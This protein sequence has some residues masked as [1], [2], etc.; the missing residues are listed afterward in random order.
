MHR[1]RDLWYL[2]LA[3]AGIVLVAMLSGCG[4]ET[5]ASDITLQ[6]P[7][8]S[9]PLVDVVLLLDQSGSM[10]GANG[11]DPNGVRVEA[12]K[13]L[14]AN[15]SEKSAEDAPNRIAIVDF[16]D[17]VKPTSASLQ[18]VSPTA[19]YAEVSAKVGVKSMGG[20][21]ALGALKAALG[22]LQ[23]AG[24]FDQGRK[25]RIVLFTDGKPEDDR[26]LTLDQYFKELK[27]FV[28]A[29]LTPLGCEVYVIAVDQVGDIWSACGSRWQ[30]LVGQDHVVRIRSVGELR[31][32]F[33]EVVN[34]I[35][36]IPSVPPDILTAGRK[37]F[38]VRPYL[39]RVEFH[40]FPSTP[41]MKLRITRPNGMP[42]S[43]TTDTD[44]RQREFKGYQIIS[45]FDP[46]A[47]EW[48]YEILQGK[49]RVEV[50]RNE[51]PLQMELVLPK[52]VHPQGKPI[53]IV[54]NFARH[55]GKPVVSE[56]NY[57]LGLSAQ[58]LGPTGSPVNVQFGPPIKGYYYG[59]PA[60][61]TKLPGLYQVTLRV[62][63]GSALDTSSSYNLRVAPLPYLELSQPRRTGLPG[64]AQ[65]ISVTGAL[66]LAGKAIQAERYF[67]NHPNLL[68]LAQVCEQPDGRK[69]PTQW[70]TSRDG[71]H[72]TTEFPL[73]MRRRLGLQQPLPGDYVIHVEHA[74]K[75]P[76]GA[77]A[78]S[79]DP[80]ML[81]VGVEAS[82]LAT[83]GQI[84]LAVAALYLGAALLSWLWVLAH[85]VR[86][87][88]MQVQL[89]VTHS[90][91][92]EALA[93]FRTVGRTWTTV[94]T[95]A[96]QDPQAPKG[97]R[98]DH[99]RGRR[100]VFWGID[101]QGTAIGYARASWGIALTSRLRRGQSRSIDRIKIQA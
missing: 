16:G 18:A 45:V 70:L 71:S 10:N 35:F 74:G 23:G 82:L 38:E 58:V 96:W 65:G 52:T 64:L 54:A 77:D 30:A 57:P 13:Y 100:L 44:T 95:K 97:K 9:A 34:D 93:S 5:P 47:G 91:T 7:Q 72:F 21:N 11:T 81:I 8:P 50:Y 90:R 92:G 1:E 87:R 68:Y 31:G 75:T 88:K 73:P 62:Q 36:S 51:V 29:E 12:A 40:V 83:V 14:I 6:L 80:S 37:S 59:E 39:D 99:F 61:S 2:A 78:A 46:Q 94:K 60:V 63:A 33:N 17:A 42:V 53:E 32:K 56:A 25:G 19:G 98:A 43:P 48:Q 49:G 28:E 26:G 76:D 66:M 15:I 20:T 86:A 85:I 41:E 67:S 89:T 84:V 27:G 4:R 22:G 79:H 55:S 69:S 24:T 101:R 3:S